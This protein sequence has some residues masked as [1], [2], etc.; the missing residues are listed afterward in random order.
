MNFLDRKNGLW[1]YGDNESP[2]DK[3]LKDMD[4]CNN[5]IMIMQI[6]NDSLKFGIYILG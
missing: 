6:I 4:W 1:S 5:D 3:V 2:F